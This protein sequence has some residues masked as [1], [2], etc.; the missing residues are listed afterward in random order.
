MRVAIKICGVRSEEDLQACLALRVEM[1]GFNFWKGSKRCITPEQAVQLIRML[2]TNVM[3]VGVFVNAS[4]AE[5]QDVL[6]RVPLHAVQLHGD[7]RVEDYAALSAQLIQV[8]KVS[9]E[10]PPDPT[11]V[12][13]RASRVL[14]DTA[15]AGHGGSGVSFDWSLA[16]RFP[17]D[18]KKDV[19]LAG[20]LTPTNVAQAIEQVRPWGVDVTS[21]VEKAPGQKDHEKLKA[22]VQAVRGVQG[23]EGKRR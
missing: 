5:I 20:G 15:T 13:P 9:A 7:E 18:A 10:K 3:G 12:S 11:V 1:I 2:H 17:A 14:L 22:F 16:S 4:P 23:P 6:G 19:I 8:I 21:G